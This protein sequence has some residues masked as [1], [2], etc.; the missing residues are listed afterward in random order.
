MY[1]QKVETLEPFSSNVIPGK[2]TEVYLGER[3]NV[4]VQA[5]HGPGWHLAT[6]PYHAEYVY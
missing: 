1:T 6:W 2:T 4:M 5:L 3:L